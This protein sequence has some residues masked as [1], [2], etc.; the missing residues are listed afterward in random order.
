M[1]R[2][3]LAEVKASVDIVE[4]IGRTVALVEQGGDFKG[5]CPFHSESTP[6]FSVNRDR[7]TFKCFGCDEGGDVVDFVRKIQGIDLR[8]A[9][10]YL[11]ENKSNV[12]P[13]KS[14]KK[15]EPSNYEAVPY[16]KAKTIFTR[17]K[18]Q[19]YADHI[20][21]KH[22]K[23]FIKAWTYKNANG[24]VELVAARFEDEAGKKD[25]LSYYFN[26]KNLKMR[27]IP[28]LL[29]G[30]DKLAKFPEMD[31]L[32]VSGEKCAEAANTLD[33]IGVTWNGGEK[34]IKTVDL[35]PLEGRNIYLWPD[36]DKPGQIWADAL[37][38][39]FPA[40]RVVDHIPEIRKKVP[41][42]A[43]IA[44]AVEFMEPEDAVKHIRAALKADD[45]ARKPTP[46]PADSST[47]PFQ[48]L[49]VAD[50]GKAYFISETERL[51]AY[52]LSSLT[53]THLVNLANVG[54][55][56]GAYGGDKKDWDL[57]QSDII[58]VSS[59][60]DFDPDRMRGRGA[61]REPDGRICYHNGK[62]VVGDISESRIYLRR[63][64]KDIGLSGSHA[65]AEAR[66][67][68]FNAA[69]DLTFT[70]FADCIRTL[71]WAVLAPFA[72]ALPWRPA[73]LLTAAS[74]TGKTTIVNSII[75]PLAMPIIC[76]GGESTAAGIRQRIGVDSCA[77]VV[78]EAEADTQK[79]KQN[80]DETFSLMRQSTSDD[81]P[82]VLKGTID[83]K[84]MR[85]TLRS[86]FFF[87]S[88]S[89]EIDNEADETRIFRVNLSKA[90]YPRE[91]WLQRDR[92]LKA[93]IT[94]EVCASIRA[95]TWV[96]IG[97]IISLS[98]R[99]AERVQMVAGIDN[100]AAF[101]ESLIIAAFIAVFK[102]EVDPPVETIDG[103]I[104]DY[105]GS[106]PIEPPR[107]E[108]AELLENYLDHI[109]REGHENWTLRDVLEIA[110]T[111]YVPGTKNEKDKDKAVFRRLAG[112]H[113]IGLDPDGNYAIARDHP[114]AMK[115]LGKGK[116]YH[117]QFLRHPGMLAKSRPVNMGG[118]TTKH[119]VVI[120][121]EVA[122]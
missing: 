57:A 22:P 37:I 42:G 12:V 64:F 43:D 120:R 49:G 15:I 112:M 75:K 117:H 108:T 26:G 52:N 111:G 56:Q 48:I 5:L 71:S 63:S 59:V 51:H 81:S 113:G 28:V 121:R 19:E 80:R 14:R 40:C 18:M 24:E 39:K 109:V 44:D 110:W 97:A 85:F 77:V 11:S 61:W 41:K 54:W 58:H 60:G 89:P 103:F 99:V 72:G 25:V 106:S 3:D 50:D 29:Y 107:N 47:W 6:S 10:E 62:K 95:Y 35:S 88:I 86:M 27:G 114:E 76:S 1:P 100:R 94:P 17:R 32:L 118:N 104:D 119:C 31:V 30:R 21:G 83:G 79:K 2:L 67:S 70:T 122:E 16:E 90:N 33:F 98:E 69:I 46:A 23:K 101:S 78:E 87:V 93:S 8:A 38:D 20:F 115:I 55:W 102:N 7:Q 105:F 36:D 65:S 13:L 66:Q 116:G 84:G 4:V 91:K 82:D 74:G 34:K 96:N 68:V 92:A 9:L 45:P 53:R 73:G